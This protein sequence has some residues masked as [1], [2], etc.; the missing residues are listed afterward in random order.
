MLRK[1]LLNESTMNE[2][3]NEYMN[4]RSAQRN[5]GVSGMFEKQGTL[6]RRLLSLPSLAVSRKADRCTVGI[7]GQ[8]RTG[9]AGG[10]PSGSN[11]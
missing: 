5:L 4:G 11:S 8:G 1:Y 6:K 7:E 2:W 9:G 3:K 10:H